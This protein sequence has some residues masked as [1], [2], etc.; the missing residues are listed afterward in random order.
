VGVGRFFSY[1]L[2]FARRDG[3][4]AGGNRELIRIEEG[5]RLKFILFSKTTTYSCPIKEKRGVF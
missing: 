3:V 4:G 2:C 1:G 5:K